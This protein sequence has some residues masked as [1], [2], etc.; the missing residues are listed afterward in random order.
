MDLFVVD[1]SDSYRGMWWRSKRGG[2]IKAW[3]TY[4]SGTSHALCPHV[5]VAP[6]SQQGS[7]M[8]NFQG[9]NLIA[10]VHRYGTVGTSVLVLYMLLSPELD[11]ITKVYQVRE[12]GVL[13]SSFEG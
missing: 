2:G 3:A 7:P 9:S 8:I 6:L 10:Y 5:E 13:G 11:Y 12:Y 4:I 1:D